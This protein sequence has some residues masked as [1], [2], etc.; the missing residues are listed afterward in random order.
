MAFKAGT[1]YSHIGANIREAM[2]GLRGPKGATW[3]PSKE[4]ALAIALGIEYGFVDGRRRKVSGRW[5]GG[6]R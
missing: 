1:K 3:T 5:V 6:S 2:K 4:Q